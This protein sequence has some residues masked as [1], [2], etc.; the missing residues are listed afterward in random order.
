M[1]VSDAV[2]VSVWKLLVVV[3]MVPAEFTAVARTV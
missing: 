3:I 2:G 1:A